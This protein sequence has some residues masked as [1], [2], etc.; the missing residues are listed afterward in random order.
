[1][2]SITHSKRYLPH[3]IDTRFY[4]VN[5]YRGGSSVQ[6][7][8][9]KYHISK[10]SLMR[11]N[12]RFD[13]SRDSLRDKSHRPISTHPPTLIRIWNSS[14]SMICTAEIL[15]SPHVRC[16][17]SFAHKRITQGT[18]VPFIRYTR[19][20]A[21]LLRLLQPRRNINHRNIT[22]LNH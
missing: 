5:L 19:L 4:T 1:M 9:R 7:V 16:M 18:Q 8:C 22:R 15:I 11:W 14:G 21:F 3:T 10:S 20:L 6:F 13:G 2:N 12:K 17:A